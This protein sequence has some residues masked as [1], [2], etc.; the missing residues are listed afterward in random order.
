M[1]SYWRWRV[2]VVYSLR[3]AAI[4]LLA[5]MITALQAQ[6]SGR[7][8]AFE[9]LETRQTAHT[10][11]AAESHPESALESVCPGGGIPRRGPQRAFLP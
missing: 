5:G 4:L 2:R 3:L 10:Q 1:I 6:S 11:R 7:E 8:R 9:I